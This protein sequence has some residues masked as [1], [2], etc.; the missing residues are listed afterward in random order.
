MEELP[1]E[2]WISSSWF[3]D[4]A[5][6]WEQSISMPNYNG[7]LSLLWARRSIENRPS[8]EDELLPELDPENFTLNRKRWPWPR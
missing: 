5:T 4:D 6:N 8:A 3:K 1:A 7:C 2:E